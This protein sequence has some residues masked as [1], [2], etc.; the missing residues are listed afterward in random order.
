MNRDTA[1]A[2]IR[3]YSPL[4]PEGGYDVATFKTLS[5]ALAYVWQQPDDAV[6]PVL[7]GAVDDSTDEKLAISIIQTLAAQPAAALAAALMNLPAGKYPTSWTLELYRHFPDL[8][9]PSH[10]RSLL[11]SES[12]EDLRDEIEELIQ[13]TCVNGDIDQ[14][15]HQ[16]QQ[17]RLAYE[18]PTVLAKADE[19][20]RQR[21]Y[22]EVARLLEPRKSLLAAAHLKKLEIAQRFLK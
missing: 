7:L 22:A 8:V 9:N 14:L 16:F 1:L 4:P 13:E 17:A 15:D 2:T 18:L 3:Q 5:Q 6:I 10:L 19:A 12:N 20:F 21:K 11:A